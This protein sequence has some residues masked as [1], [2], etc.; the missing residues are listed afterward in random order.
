MTQPDLVW[1]DE[2]PT[3]SGNYWLSVHPDKRGLKWDEVEY[4]RVTIYAA[5]KLVCVEPPGVVCDKPIGLNDPTY[6]KR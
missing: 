3:E 5:Y 6:A 4:V 2:R 1:S